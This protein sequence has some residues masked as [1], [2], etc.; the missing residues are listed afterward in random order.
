[1]ICHRTMNSTKAENFM[2]SAKAPQISAG[3]MM[4]KVIWKH[5]NTDSGI[6]PLR[7]RDVHAFQHEPATCRRYRRSCFHHR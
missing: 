5:M 6:V 4:A 1:M 7:V 3:V 2:R